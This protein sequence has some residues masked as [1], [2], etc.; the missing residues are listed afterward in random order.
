MSVAASDA[1]KTSQNE[2]QSIF[3]LKSV[4]L[5][6]PKRLNFREIFCGISLAVLPGVILL[7]PLALQTA[8]LIFIPIYLRARRRAKI[9]S[10]IHIRYDSRQAERPVIVRPPTHTGTAAKRPM[11]PSLAA[12]L[13]LAARPAAH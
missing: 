4:D 13:H 6:G 7:I 9:R 2:T 12:R 1:N 10:H 3:K 5:F 11:R 8:V